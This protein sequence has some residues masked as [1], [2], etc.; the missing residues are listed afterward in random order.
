MSSEENELRQYIREIIKK[1]LDEISTSAGAGPYMT[2]MA[3]QGNI[4]KN[5]NKKRRIATQLGWILTKRGK[6]QLS[7]PADNLTEIRAPYYDFR[8]M[9]GLP[10]KKIAEKISEINKN[11]D[12]IER[13]IKM[14]TRYQSEVGVTSEELY[15]RTRE[16]LRK[17]ENRLLLLGVK[18]REIRGK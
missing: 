2:P 12:M 11:V 13:L 15:S 14:S 4:S 1:E 8:D 16:S 5:I 18:I 9:E 7:R 17:L 3:F 6:E 10:Q